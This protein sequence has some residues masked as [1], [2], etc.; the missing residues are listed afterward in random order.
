MSVIFCDFFVEQRVSLLMQEDEDGMF[1]LA[2]EEAAD[3]PARVLNS[4][5]GPFLI[6]NNNDDENTRPAFTDS[7]RMMDLDE[8]QQ[9]LQIQRAALRKM[10]KLADD[11][12]PYVLVCSEAGVGAS[13]RG[14]HATATFCHV[15]KKLTAEAA[16]EEEQDEV[17]DL[18]WAARLLAYMG[19]RDHHIIP[20]PREGH[21]ESFQDYATRLDGLKKAADDLIATQR[22]CCVAIQEDWPQ[23]AGLGRVWL[24][25]SFSRRP[26][27]V[28]LGH[29]FE[30]L[31][32]AVPFYDSQ[33][34][35]ES[36]KVEQR[37]VWGEIL[38]QFRGQQVQ[39]Q[40]N[41]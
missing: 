18:D 32:N 37:A 6:E 35:E 33:Q 17:S 9:R 11:M 34:M 19:R 23:A 22:D 38:Q 15:A 27:W 28:V 24:R 29:L 2:A 12:I 39:A 8:D 5:D 10:A 30:V 25:S 7:S 4:S 36:L 31:R 41:I 26:V 40:S 1:V 13:V 16:A 21:A 20:V 14:G 3:P